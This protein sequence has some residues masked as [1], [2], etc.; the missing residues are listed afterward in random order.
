MQGWSWKPYQ[1]APE[2]GW[3]VCPRADADSEGV[4]DR[5]GKANKA[6]MIS[7]SYPANHAG[8]RGVMFCGRDDRVVCIVKFGF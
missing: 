4:N 6:I 5:A 1:D 7:F 3:E 2:S 8:R